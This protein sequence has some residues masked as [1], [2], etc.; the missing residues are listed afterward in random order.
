VPTPVHTIRAH[1]SRISAVAVSPDGRTVVSGDE[2]GHVWFSALNTGRAM[3]S[4]RF[5]DSPI[6]E[7]RF[8]PTGDTLAVMQRDQLTLVTV[9]AHR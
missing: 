7:L 9:E 1:E 6:Y 5:A 3:F 8:S 2:T 4:T